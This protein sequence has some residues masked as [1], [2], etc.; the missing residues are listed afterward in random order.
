MYA[1]FSARFEELFI[2]TWFPKVRC[3]RITTVGNACSKAVHFILKFSL[4][5]ELTYKNSK[6]P[7]KNKMGNKPT[8]KYSTVSNGN[9]FPPIDTAITP[10][11]IAIMLKLTCL[12]RLVIKIKI[13]KIDCANPITEIILSTR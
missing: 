11:Q 12:G 2:D 8:L 4:V 6:G 9:S 1:G 3:M 13:P 5:N 10:S 7:C